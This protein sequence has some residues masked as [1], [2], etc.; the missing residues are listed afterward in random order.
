MFLFTFEQIFN[1][2]L[3]ISPYFYKNLKNFCG[4]KEFRGK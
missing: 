1:L 3:L 2:Y 4:E